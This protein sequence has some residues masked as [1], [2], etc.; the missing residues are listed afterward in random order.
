MHRN[1]SIMTLNV[2]YILVDCQARETWK[3]HVV[4]NRDNNSG[5]LHRKDLDDAVPI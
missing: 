4:T 2:I 3:F 5:I 1:S